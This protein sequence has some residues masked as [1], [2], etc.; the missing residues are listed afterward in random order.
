MV[1]PENTCADLPPLYS[2]WIAELLPGPIPRES[3]ATCDNCAMC[4]PSGLQDADQKEYFDPDA[5]CC[6][7]VPELHNF[8]AGGILCDDDP[9]AQPGRRTVEHRIRSGV[10]VTPLGL[11]QPPVFLVL[12]ESG[13]SAFGRS[14]GLRCPHYLEQGGGRCGV[15]RHRE[16][17]CMTWF[18]KHVRGSIG[19]AFWRDSLHQLLM[20]VE[21]DLARWAVMEMDLGFEALKR[22]V[23]T[24]DWRSQAE[25]L[26]AESIDNRVDREAYARI[27][28][29]W[30]GR[31]EDFFVECARLVNGLSWQEVMGIA[32]PEARAYVRLTLEAYRKLISDEVPAALK[33]GTVQL[34]QLRHDV[35]RLS[36]YSNFD[37]IDVPR[38]V[39][40]SLHY[41]DG[42]PVSDALAAIASEKNVLMERSL[43]RKM[44]DFGLLVAAGAD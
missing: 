3:R 7:F 14:K 32:R 5:K 12:Y 31:E 4:A 21:K 42:R 15:W 16:S 25:P 9:A 10:A 34:V 35:T 28:G 38:V 26:T 20:V 37:P 36:A 8:L 1:D 44:V 13:P 23:A 22:L 40:E 43:V 11:K 17:T 30:A 39:M 19:Y 41:F 24:N 6:T 27:W 29:K 2:R 33:V 18:C